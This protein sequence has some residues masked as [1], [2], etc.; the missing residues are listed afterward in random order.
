MS[1]AA[2]SSDGNLR[3]Y[4]LACAATGEYTTYFGGTVAA[5]MSA[6]VTAI[7]RINGIYEPELGIRLI[8]VGNNNLLIYTNSAT[9]PYTDNSP[10]LLLSQNQS[11]L[12]Y[13]IGNSNYD[14]G[15]VRYRACIRHGRRRTG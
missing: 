14:I 5:G 15:H 10:S 3:T 13:V 12:D 4:R 7:N 6:I 9:D 8:L 11:N 1:A 2:L